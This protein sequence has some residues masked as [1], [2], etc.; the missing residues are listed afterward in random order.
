MVVMHSLKDMKLENPIIML[1]Y[2]SLIFQFIVKWISKYNNYMK[3]DLMQLT[4]PDMIV[5]I[6]LDQWNY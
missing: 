2:N 3:V 1:A 5:S 4:L 6:L